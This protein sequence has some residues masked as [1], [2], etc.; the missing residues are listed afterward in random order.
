MA[1]RTTP[2]RIARRF[3]EQHAAI[4]GD[5]LKTEARYLA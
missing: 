3:R 4:I 5:C 2:C 1:P